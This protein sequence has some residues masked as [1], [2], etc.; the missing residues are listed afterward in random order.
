MKSISAGLPHSSCFLFAQKHTT[1]DLKGMKVNFSCHLH[2]KLVQGNTTIQVE[3][4][5]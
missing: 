5:K 2:F 3:A 1:E 4:K